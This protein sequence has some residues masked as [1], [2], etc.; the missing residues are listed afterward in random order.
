MSRV[1]LLSPAHSGGLRAGLLTRAGATFDLARRFQIGDAE[2]GEV[3]TFCSG[4][5]FRGK[6]TYARRF[7]LPPPGVAGVQVITSSRGL[8]PPETQIY[9][10]DLREFSI[11]DVDIDEPR[12]VAPLQAAARA[13]V[14]S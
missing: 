11:V 14:E 3:F 6:L 7:A 5:Y 2:L 1:F 12:F 4:L 9:A 10:A 13:L 8:L